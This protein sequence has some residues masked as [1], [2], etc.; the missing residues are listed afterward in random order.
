LLKLLIYQI[1]APS[2]QLFSSCTT[3]TMY[4]LITNLQTA[5]FKCQIKK[6]KW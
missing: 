4:H 1:H 5:C 6:N 2:K 3:S